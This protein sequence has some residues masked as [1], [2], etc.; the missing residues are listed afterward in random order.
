MRPLRDRAHIEGTCGH[1]VPDK[2]E[3]ERELHSLD[4]TPRRTATL[5]TSSMA[6]AL[7][8]ADIELGAARRLWSLSA[9]RR[10]R[11]WEQNGSD[12]AQSSAVRGGQRDRFQRSEQ[13]R[14]L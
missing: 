8:W 2:D 4:Q 13:G 6:Q 7:R 10:V 12:R 3:K 11:F 5:L 1:N 9:G 14:Y